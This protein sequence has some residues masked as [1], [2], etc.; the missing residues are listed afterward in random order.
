M[1]SLAA[2]LGCILDNYRLLPISSNIHMKIL[3]IT[4]NRVG[5]AVLS[6]GLLGWL[7]D[8][9]PQ[10]RFTVVCGQ[11][12]AGLF[13]AVPNL[14]RL[15]VMRKRRWNLHWAALW[16]ECVGTK[17]DIIVDLRNSAISRLLLAG[18]RAYAPPRSTGKHKVRD[19]AAALEL[20]SSPPAPRLWLDARSESAARELLKDGTLALALAPAANWTP[21]Q[22]P[23][24][25]FAE[26][27]RQ[28]TAEGGIMPFAKIVVVAAPHERAAIAAVLELP[29]VVEV[30]GDDLLLAAACVERCG[31][32]VGNDSGLMHIA[33]A[34]GVPTLGLFGPGNE[35]VYGPWGDRVA[36]LRTPQSASNLLA[37]LAEMP[38]PERKSRSLMD[39]ISVEMALD[40][41]KRLMVFP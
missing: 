12:P 16:R 22:W 36:V 4:S 6:S 5:D 31:L 41:A 11:P 38:E 18:K 10:A 40:A 19:N 28:A 30:I 1:T 34:V 13:R 2:A 14:E 15:I 32:F 24:E 3:F 27:A 9:Y 35:S 26:F 7:I 8:R 33:A 25:R 39:G 21:K 17:W 23:P 29:N 37:R 20:E